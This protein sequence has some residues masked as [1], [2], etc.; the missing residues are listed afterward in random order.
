MKKINYFCVNTK[1]NILT[2]LFTWVGSGG[3]LR[4][5]LV[6]QHKVFLPLIHKD[7]SSLL[8]PAFGRFSPPTH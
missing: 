5:G 1:S 6:S 7:F 3:G 8:K 4:S 2:I